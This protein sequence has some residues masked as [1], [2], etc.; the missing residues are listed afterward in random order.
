VLCVVQ[1]KQHGPNAKRRCGS[2]SGIALGAGGRSQHARY[3]RCHQGRIRQRCQ[4]DPP[5]T[6]GKVR[7][8]RVGDLLREAGLAEAG[9]TKQRHLP[10]HGQVRHQFL[11][12]ALTAQQRLVTGWQIGTSRRIG[13]VRHGRH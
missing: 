3:G 7:K 8:S 13:P 10:G 12:L 9:A 1:Y 4:I 5:D 11:L 6:F 2:G